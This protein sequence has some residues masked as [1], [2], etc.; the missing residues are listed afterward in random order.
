[1]KGG[2]GF[3]RPSR[4]PPLGR[5]P[6]SLHASPRA[7]L[8]LY[9]RWSGPSRVA[10]ERDAGPRPLSALLP[11]PWHPALGQ[12]GPSSSRTVPSQ[13][14]PLLSTQDNHLATTTWTVDV[15]AGVPH[16]ARQAMHGGTLDPT[17]LTGRESRAARPALS[18]RKRTV[19]GLE[20]SIF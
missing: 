12:S 19:P 8:S 17:T 11:R 7:R 3:S 10:S 2:M 5:A 20:H 14:T 1:M 4:T 16:G 18:W 9:P 6:P 15:I 13:R